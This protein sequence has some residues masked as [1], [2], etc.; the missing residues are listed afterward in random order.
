MKA[1]H[2]LYLNLFFT[3]AACNNYKGDQNSTKILYQGIN[4]LDTAILKVK[5]IDDKTFYG[6]LEINYHGAYKD[7]GNVTGIIKGDTLKGSYH[8]QHYRIETWRRIPIALLKKDDK[9]IMGM[10]SMEIYMNITYF[11][12]N[13]PINYKNP[14]FIFDRQ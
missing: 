10:G 11:K 4:N 13:T 8:F 5:L 14:L 9:L 7:S 6:Q 1:I 2:I 12:K 3:L